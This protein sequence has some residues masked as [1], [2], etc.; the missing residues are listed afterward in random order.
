MIVLVK[1]LLMLCFAA[2]SLAAV[3]VVIMAVST[4]GL[5]GFLPFTTVSKDVFVKAAP[6]RRRVLYLIV[7]AVVVCVLLAVIEIAT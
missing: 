2:L 4:V 6:Y 7:A 1:L 3:F 5:G